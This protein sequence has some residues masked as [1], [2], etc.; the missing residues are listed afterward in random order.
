MRCRW[1]IGLLGILVLLRLQHPPAIVPDMARRPAPA[2]QVEG[3]HGPLSRA[4]SQAV[5]DRL[6]GGQPT[7]IFERHLAVEEAI[8]G[9]PLTAGNKVTLL[10]DGPTTYQAMFAAI[11]ARATTSTWRPTSSTTMRSAG[12]SRRP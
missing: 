8:A 10:Q 5:V 1:A 11:A 2:V 6:A 7:N 12:G 3:T 9:S 4:R